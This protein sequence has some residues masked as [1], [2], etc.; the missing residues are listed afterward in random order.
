MRRSISIVSFV[1]AGFAAALWWSSSSPVGAGRGEAG[2]AASSDDGIEPPNI[3]NAPIAAGDDGDARGS[4]GSRG[5]ASASRA[6][7][8]A[9]SLSVLIV[10]SGSANVPWV[11][12]FSGVG[13]R[14]RVF[15]GL[16]GG[17]A[18]AGS[19]MIATRGEGSNPDF[20]GVVPLVGTR[21]KDGRLYKLSGQAGR[22][23]FTMELVYKGTGTLYRALDDGR[24]QRYEAHCQVQ[25]NSTY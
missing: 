13:D 1:A 25:P 18:V 2:F 23:S 20:E 6:P 16:D 3:V 17:D 12:N 19:A 21:T 5:P 11:F 15:F 4:A 24:P 8:S 14:L 22:H 10:C 9:D 7:A